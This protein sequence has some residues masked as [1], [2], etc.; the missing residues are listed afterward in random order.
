MRARASASTA[1]SRRGNFTTGADKTVEWTSYNYPRRIEHGEDIVAFSY[2]PDR[3]RYTES[4]YTTTGGLQSRTL[5]IGAHFEQVEENDIT[6]YKHHIRAGAKVIAIHDRK[7]DYHHTTH[8]LHRDHLGSVDTI[9]DESGAVVARMSFDAFGL[10]RQSL[11]WNDRFPTS[12]EL[13]TIRDIT[14]S[15]TFYAQNTEES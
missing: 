7:S 9:T 2:G 6:T 12:T 14:L 10:R 11:N 4:R 15:Y 1:T 3:Q 8:Y 13:D 5:V